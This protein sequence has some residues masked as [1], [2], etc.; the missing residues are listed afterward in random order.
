MTKAQIKQILVYSLKE[1]QKKSGKECPPINDDTNPFDDLPGFDSLLSLEATVAL[2]AK[3]GRKLSK[4]SVFIDSEKN[5]GRKL[6]EVVDAVMQLL[7]KE[8]AA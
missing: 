3:L 5:R 4:E 6:S 7:E 1:I 8:S 2:E